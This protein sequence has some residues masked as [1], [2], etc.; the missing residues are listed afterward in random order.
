MSDLTYEQVLNHACNYEND[1]EK[2]D[3]F[4]IDSNEDES[5]SESG[6][7]DYNFGSQKVIM[8]LI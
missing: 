6:D 2:K 1:Q 4:D 7:D 3:K 5:E 8:N